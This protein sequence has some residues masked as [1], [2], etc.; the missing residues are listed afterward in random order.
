MRKSV[1]K[2]IQECQTCQQYKSQSQKVGYLSPIT[3]T[4]P[5]E[6]IGWDLMDP[7]PTSVSGNKYIL[8]TTEYLTRWCIT[9]A[10][11]DISAHT[12]AHIL[13]HQLILQHSCPKQLLS[14]QGTQF[15]GEVL[16]GLTQVLGIKQLFLLPITPRLTVLQSV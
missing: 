10:I 9:A 4:E 16:Q 8:A 6:M 7:F 3:V 11:P 15:R 13:L 2:H 12:V 5:F 1:A 14:D